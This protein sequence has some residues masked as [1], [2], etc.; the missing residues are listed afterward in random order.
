MRIPAIFMAIGFFM[1]SVAQVPAQTALSQATPLQLV[2][3]VVYNELHDHSTHGY[4]RFH[5][6]THMHNK[7]L[8][9]DQV[10]TIDGPVSRIALAD[11]HPLSPQDDRD[12]EARLLHLL[13]SP[14]EQEQLRRQH[15][16][17]EQ[18][19]THI[20][21]LLPQAFLFDYDGQED[22]CYRLRFHPNPD[23]S[24]SAVEARIFHAMSGT[25]WID[26]RAK[27]LAKLEGRVDSNVDFGFGILGRVYRGGWFLLQRT[28]VSP[29]EWKTARLEIHMNAR[30]LMMKT[31]AKET[32]EIR[33]DFVR[34]PAGTT[35][36]RGVQ[37]L[38]RGNNGAEEPEVAINALRSATPT[39]AMAF[40]H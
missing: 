34:V 18:R 24:S 17:D 37:L 1:T 32:S 33:E 9:S 3:E 14:S 13:G 20:L 30:A 11:G 21:S 23:Y 19:I 26:R 36:S 25:L 29:T 6:T 40:R 38:E 35:L 2:R 39:E 31:I 8:V 16:Q 15:R 7:T 12:E 10:E 27:H 4:W 22:G 28:Q 5:V